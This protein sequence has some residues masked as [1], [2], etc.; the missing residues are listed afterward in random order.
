MSLKRTPLN[1][2]HRDHGAKM[3]DFGGWDMPIQF[4][5]ILA[6]H[7]AVR[8][9]AGLFD[10]SHMGEVRVHGDDALAFIQQ[11]ITNDASTLERGQA[12]YTVM[13][14]EDGG[15]IDDL[16][17]YHL[18]DSDYLLVINASTTPKDVAWIESQAAVFGGDVQVADES[19]NWAQ[20]AVQGPCAEEILARIVPL[21]LSTVRYYRSA[22]SSF[23][24]AACLVSRTGYTGEDG[25]EVYLPPAKAP[26]LADAILAAGEE[27]GIEPV[28]LGARDTLRLEAGMLL[29]G[30]DMDESRSPVEANLRWLIKPD[31]GD[32]IGREAILAQIESGTDDKLVAFELLQRGV[33]RHGY[34]LCAADGEPFGEV[35]SGSFSPTLQK[36][37]GLGYVPTGQ[38]QVD[39]ELK[40]DVR[41]RKLEARIV[42][43]PFYRRPKSS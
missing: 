19:G 14:Y 9:R 25:F 28:G 3:V 39:G 23:D 35:T 43:A 20:L 1:Q 18:D 4:S 33:P 12:Q 34:A 24:D 15:V 5:G 16:L 7:E 41:G 22:E 30:N 2:W 38:A 40:V 17:V 21:D 10:V 26:A 27:E 6:E 42:K 32:F 37:I 29:Y 13:V 8:E 11:L 31:K 36:G